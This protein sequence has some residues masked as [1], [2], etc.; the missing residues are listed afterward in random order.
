M[1]V[2]I[3]ATAFAIDIDVGGGCPG[4]TLISGTGATGLG[5]VRVISGSGPGG[6]AI[7]TDGCAVTSGL[8]GP[9]ARGLTTADALG[10]ARLSPKLGAGACGMWLQLLDTTTCTLS[11]VM[12]IPLV[13]HS[14]GPDFSADG[15]VQCQGYY[16]TTSPNEI[17]AAWG[18]DCTGPSD[19]Q[20][21]MVCGPNDASYRFID[22]NKNPFRDGLVSYPEI[23]LIF[24]A[25]F[26]ITTNEIYATGNHP[27]IGVSW[28]QNGAGCGELQLNTTVNNVCSWEASNCF[29]QGLTGDRYLWLYTRP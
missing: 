13:G 9:V 5:G 25:N 17:P 18:A 26:G 6:D 15:W 14:P 29:G 19:N 22:V 12:Q 8:A 28:W 27:H 4:K 7:T 3:A 11:G 2:L 10:N 24:D 20:I 16:D 23:G 1:L 21:R